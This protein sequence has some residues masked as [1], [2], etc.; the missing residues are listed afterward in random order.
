MS[1]RFPPPPA[2]PPLENFTRE[3]LVDMVHRLHGGWAVT[4]DSL[5]DLAERTEELMKSV[6][7]HLGV[8]PNGGVSE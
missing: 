2:I 4:V 7:K 5:N 8:T 1:K 6:R 3:M